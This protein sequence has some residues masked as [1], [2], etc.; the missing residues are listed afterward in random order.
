MSK[1]ILGV[2]AGNYMAKVAGP[3]GVDSY[4]TAICEWFERNI[5]ESFADDDMEFEIAGRKGFAGTIA[6]Y[7]DVFGGSGAM[8]GD[9]KAHEDTKIRVLLA[10]HRYTDK[11]CPGVEDVT[12]VTGQPIVSHVDEEKERIQEMLV[13]HHKFTVNGTK[14]HIQIHNVGVSA[15]GAGAYWSSPEEGTIRILDIGSG[16]VNAATIIDTKYINNASDTFN[17]GMETVDTDN[18]DS[19]ARGIVRATTRLKWNRNDSVYICGGI[20]REILPC[21]ASHYVN[22]RILQPIL[23][24]K[25]FV[26]VAEPV[27]SNAIGFYKLAKGVLG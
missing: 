15:E 6:A 16:T 21:I 4:R 27:F 3:Y 26:T 1:L 24:E 20:A 14:R 5:E 19:V 22:A 7:E 8:F 13:G 18:L 23:D 17:F 9:S 2:D 12:L 11:Y 25:G 10:I